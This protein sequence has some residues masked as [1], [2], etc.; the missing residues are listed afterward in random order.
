MCA[1]IGFCVAEGSLESGAS[2]TIS[3]S[4]ATRV[5]AALEALKVS[6]PSGKV[7]GY[8]CDLS[9]P[10][11]ESDI[12]ALFEKT[13]KLDHIVFTAGDRLATIPLQE[14]TFEK[15]L[16]A[17][18]VRFFAALFVAKV[19]SRYLSPGPLSSITLTTG[20]VAEHPM[21]NWSAVASYASGLHGMTR[22]LAVDLKPIRV[23]LVS[24]GVVLTELW[25][26]LS[27]DARTTLIK[28]VDEKAFTGTIGKPE[29]VAEAYLWLMKDANVTGTVVASESGSKLA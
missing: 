23:N 8:A 16:K 22:N 13:G 15:M 24:P 7:T 26:H 17:G 18:Q 5:E 9:K 29:D 10:T 20:S 27:E 19:G 11:V 14:I 28:R 12:E 21:P 25:D 1:G 2:V 4:S 6:Y 3:S